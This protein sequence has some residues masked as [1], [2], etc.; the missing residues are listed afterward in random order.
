MGLLAKEPEGGDFKL[1]P[2]G[3]HPARCYRVIDLGT[4]NNERYG[5]LQHKVFIGFE[6]YGDTDDFRTDDGKPLSIAMWHTVSLGDKANLRRD[7]ESWRGKAFTPEELSGFDVSNLLGAPALMNIIH[8][9]N[10]SGKTYAN[11]ASINPLPGAMKDSIPPEPV[12]APLL[13]DLDKFDRDVFEQLPNGLQETIQ[14]SIEWASIQRTGVNAPKAGPQSGTP[15]PSPAPA[16]V[17]DMDDDI[18]F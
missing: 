3:M 17:D 9:T 5:K 14:R 12:V 15:N 4:Q 13:L 18:P 6:V 2:P 11:I 16:G 7:L 1:V 8:E 10:D